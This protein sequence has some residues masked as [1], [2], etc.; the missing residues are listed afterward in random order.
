MS[1]DLVKN[2]EQCVFLIKDSEADEIVN[3]PTFWNNNH[4]RVKEMFQGRSI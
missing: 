1:A 4:R 3:T 2:Q